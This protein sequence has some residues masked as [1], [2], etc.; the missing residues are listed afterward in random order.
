MQQYYPRYYLLD[1]GS[2][3]DSDLTLKLAIIILCFRW[4][5]ITRQLTIVTSQYDTLHILT[6]L[7]A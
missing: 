1:S 7:E 6:L 2:D 5:C 3:P 4:I